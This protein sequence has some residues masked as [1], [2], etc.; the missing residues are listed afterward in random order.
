MM[1]NGDETAWWGWLLMSLMMVAFW[2]GVIVLVWY[3]VTHAGSANQPS[4]TA[5]SPE[6]LLDE[7]FARGEIDADEYRERRDVLRGGAGRKSPA[8]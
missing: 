5:R 8:A 3:L 2:G 4:K 1:W 6:Q 7:R